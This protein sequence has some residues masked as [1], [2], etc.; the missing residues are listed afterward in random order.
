MRY[1]VLTCIVLAATGHALDLGLA[2]G[3]V[4]T[5]PGRLSYYGY[6]ATRPRLFVGLC[7]EQTVGPLAM[8]ACRVGCVTATDIW[9]DDSTLQQTREEISGWGAQLG[10]YAHAWVVDDKLAA[11]GGLSV[12]YSSTSTTCWQAEYNVYREDQ[13]GFT[14]GIQVG[15][16]VR[17]TTRLAFGLDCGVPLLGQSTIAVRNPYGPYDRA[18][19]TEAGSMEPSVDLLVLLSL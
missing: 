18:R 2:A 8:L 6:S 7:A 3:S 1:V 12:R 13:R 9:T 14:E 16:R 17:A 19:V 4:S 10:L 5:A 15:A 11:L